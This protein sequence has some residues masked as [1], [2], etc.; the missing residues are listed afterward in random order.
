MSKFPSFSL[1]HKVFAVTRWKEVKLLIPVH[2]GLKG[3][4]YGR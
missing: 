4:T 1:D 2:V 3:V